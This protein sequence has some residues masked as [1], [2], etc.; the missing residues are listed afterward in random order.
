MRYVRRHQR[1]RLFAVN[2]H[3]ISP[4]CNRPTDRPSLRPLDCPS[5]N[6]HM[7]VLF[8]FSGT[9][10]LQRGQLHGRKAAKVVHTY[11]TTFCK[12]MQMCWIKILFTASAAQNAN[13]DS[14]WGNVRQKAN[15]KISKCWCHTPTLLLQQWPL[16]LICMLSVR[17][18]RGDDMDAVVNCTH[19]Q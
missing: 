11:K 4:W 13:S 7:F 3:G 8:N 17:Q 14:D 6:L 18:T 16:S 1:L 19:V 2:F 12:T 5:G 9:L 10:H 15:K